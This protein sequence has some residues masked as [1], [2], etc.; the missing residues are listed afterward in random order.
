MMRLTTNRIL[1]RAGILILALLFFSP[2]F[3]QDTIRT[4][5]PKSTLKPSTRL[6]P[7][8]A[9]SNKI[10]VSSVRPVTPDTASASIAKPRKEH[11]PQTAMLLSLI[12][13]GGQIYNGQAWKVPVI[14][15]AIGTLGYLVY[16]NYSK[17]SV[18]KDDY[19]YCI[20]NGLSNSQLPEYSSYPTTSIYN[21]YQS[22]NKNF[23]L[24]IIISA[25]IY[26]LNLVDAYVFGHLYDFQIN[27]DLTL[28]VEP[29]VTPFRST[30]SNPI[31]LTSGMRLTLSF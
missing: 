16:D 11:S 30:I 4:I 2:S 9:D 22:Y 20:N 5:T 1:F 15:A 27:D 3:A 7:V 25:G 31:S 8:S 26:A 24:M 13:G 10:L 12:P 14:Y 18:F 6:T 23:Q 17:M 21:L 19:L 29:M 28:R